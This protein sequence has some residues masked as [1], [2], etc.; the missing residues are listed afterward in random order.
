MCKSQKTNIKVAN[1]VW[2]K[3]NEFEYLCAIEL[4]T[5]VNESKSCFFFPPQFPLN[6]ILVS[7]EYS[8]TR[9][10]ITG[11]TSSKVEERG[12][13]LTHTINHIQ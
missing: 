2:W 6:V 13:K 3:V 5:T 4:C 10:Y 9:F 8:R 12:Q 7:V 11:D 1:G